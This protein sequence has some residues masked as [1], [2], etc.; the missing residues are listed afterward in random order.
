[1][2][3]SDSFINEVTEEVRRD[4]LYGLMRRWGWV[5]ALLIVG[6]VSGA[7]YFEW[8]SAQDQSAAQAFGDA[9]LDGLDLP[10]AEE[11]IAAL[12]AISPGSPEAAMI[13]ALLES[14]QLASDDQ[15]QA[16]AD[17]L[18]AA[19]ETPDIDR[20][21]RDLALLRAEM[22][23]PSAPAEARLVLE[24]LAEPGAPYAALAQEQLALLALRDGDLDGALELLRRIEA[25]AATT[26]GLQQRASQLI[27]ALEAGSTLVETRPDPEPEQTAPQAEAGADDAAVGEEIGAEDGAADPASGDASSGTAAEADAAQDAASENQ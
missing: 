16:A 24:V 1:M 5:P 14:S 8:R 19:A 10:E 20:R 26:A 9:L 13:L 2:S 21:Y 22:L 12:D 6:I 3:D 15:A 11:R 25:G 7:A 4:R 23:A 27:V 17:G 18:R